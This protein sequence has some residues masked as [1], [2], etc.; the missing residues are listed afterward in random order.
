MASNLPTVTTDATTG[1][2]PP[3]G[4]GGSAAPGSPLADVLTFI[5]E[6]I[7]DAEA[8]TK[9]S[10]TLP[11]GQLYA[12]ISSHVH[13]FVT[14]ITSN[15]DEI[16]QTI[17]RLSVGQF[18][19]DMLRL[20]LGVDVDQFDQLAKDGVQ[21]TDTML[22]FAYIMPWIVAAASL[23]GKIPLAGR[24]IEAA[25]EPI[26]QLPEE[27][28]L[29]WALGAQIEAAYEAAVGES[30]LEGIRR[31]KRSSRIEWPILRT[32]LRQHVLDEAKFLDLLRN[33]G[34]PEEQ[35][36]WIKGLDQTQ[37]TP[38]D[39]QRLWQYNVL[40]RKG[41]RQALRH[42]GYTEGDV[43]HLTTLYIDHAE[44]QA[45]TML[46]STARELVRGRLITIPMYQ[47]ILQSTNVPEREW[48]DDIAAIN[49]ELSHGHLLTNL[50]TLRNLY[51]RGQ[52][53]ATQARLELEQLGYTD[54]AIT[55]T[56]AGWDAGPAPRP[57]SQAKILSYYVSG[58]LKAEQARA[59]LLLAGT[60]AN[61]IAL[62]LE[63][64]NDTPR[65]RP[66]RLTP[67]LVIQAFLDGALPYDG[68]QAALEAAGT[69]GDITTYYLK[70]AVYKQSRQKRPAG[71]TTPLTVGQI[72]DA[73][74]YGILDPHTALEELEHAGYSPDDALILL[75]IKFKGSNPFVA[76]PAPL[77]TDVGAAMQFLESLGWQVQPPPDPRIAAAESLLYSHGYQL[78]PPTGQWTGLGTGQGG[79]ATGGGGQ[80]YLGP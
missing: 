14:F 30:I 60:R 38:G 41:F 5:G 36:T 61:D 54:Q 10:A 74:A 71:A 40:D 57:L 3:S 9:A 49:L 72:L 78:T 68:L 66:R 25:L 46:R 20:G 11:L 42:I 52:T 67:G 16:W 43:N 31:Q 69:T 58:V 45:G 55:D 24:W 32:M 56:L 76:G 1:P 44:S 64:A 39:L 4:F 62:L 79:G 53:S 59:A 27:M 29:S 12:A 73:A 80:G 6:I 23:A 33:Q 8:A 65:A 22:G 13:R 7:G 37:L 47:A 17:T 21:T 2:P 63:H 28:G 18:Y 77:F 50:T 51:L 35:I 26:A 15:P 75:E 19:T 34:F 48:Q 70:M